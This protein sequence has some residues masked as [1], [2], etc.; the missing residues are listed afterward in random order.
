MSPVVKVPSLELQ[1]GLH[2]LLGHGTGKLFY[3]GEEG[4]NFPGGLVS[5][6]DGRPVESWYGK[7]ETYDGRF[8][9]LASTF[10]EC[11]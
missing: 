8:T 10:E 6:L 2:E 7:G 3:K 4:Q 9:S 11:R 5:P 1:V